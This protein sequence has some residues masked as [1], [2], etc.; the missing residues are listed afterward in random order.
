MFPF[1]RA[2]SRFARGRACPL[3]LAALLAACGPSLSPEAHLATERSFLRLGVELANEDEQVR[4]VLAQRHLSVAAEVRG[5]IFIGL[6]A[7]TLDSRLSAIR[8]LAP[9]SPCGAPVV[10]DAA[11]SMDAAT[12][13]LA[14]VDSVAATPE[15]A[16]PMPAKSAIGAKLETTLA[17]GSSDQPSL[18]SRSASS[19]PPTS[20]PRSTPSVT[21]DTASMNET[22]SAR[23]IELDVISAASVKTVSDP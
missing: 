7:S 23:A 10:D 20:S 12:D 5:P 11:G 17:L 16:N 19:T 9:S 21:L 14:T 6:G 1:L 15:A 8:V 3:R 13:V 2:G 18:S 4:H 22:P